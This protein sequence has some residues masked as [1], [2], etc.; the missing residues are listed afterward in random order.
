MSLIEALILGLIQGLTEFLP[1]SSSGHIALGSY[2]LGTTAEEPL[3]FTIL[4]HGA[5]AL[6]TIVVF[7]KDILDIL[8]GLFKFQWNE[9][10]QFTLLILISLV[11]L[12]IIGLLFESTIDD[13]FSDNLSLV[14]GMLLVTAL[15]LSL[16][17]FKPN[18]SG[19]INWWKASIIGIAQTIAILPGISRSGA[20]IA[21]GLYLNVD[22]EKATRFSFL[23]VLPAILGA[24][25]IK[26]IGLIK[27]PISSPEEYSL[28]PLLVGFISAFIAGWFACKWMIKIVK[29]GKLVYFAIYCAIVGTIGLILS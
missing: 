28:L 11:P 20:T 5:T 16:T 13:L 29:N 1:V 14:S 18:T 22:K 9:S 3:L 17:Y 27:T 7:R 2:I 15:L 19:K 6:S 12:V 26:T 4:V 24:S 8:K 21:T 25:F 10:L 23:M